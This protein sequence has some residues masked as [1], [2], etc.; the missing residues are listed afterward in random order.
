MKN[1]NKYT[2]LVFNGLPLSQTDGKENL[3]NT[4]GNGPQYVFNTFL[5]LTVI[6]EFGLDVAGIY[7]PAQKL[8]V[9]NIVA[10]GRP[11]EFV[12]AKDDADLG[13]FCFQQSQLIQFMRQHG[14]LVEQGGNRFTLMLFVKQRNESMK[15]NKFD[16]F[17][18][19]M[20]RFD[21]APQPSISRFTEVAGRIYRA[22]QKFRLVVPTPAVL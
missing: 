16:V 13:R 9:H 1:N 21:G 18:A 5:G 8:D 7:T 11:M 2:R 4:N 10:D 20:N 12:G 3:I 6:E 14:K 19:A 15:V 22:K 17:V